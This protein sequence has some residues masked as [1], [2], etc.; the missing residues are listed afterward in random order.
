M[1][2]K[3]HEDEMPSIN[4]TP[5]V[6]I[7]FQ[8][9]IFFMVGTKFTEMEKKIDLSVPSVANS[10]TLP[11]APEKRIVNVYRDGRIELDSKSVSLEQLQSEL[12]TW[13][14][15]SAN[16]SVVVRGDAEGALQNVASVLTACRDAGIS[17][18]GISVRVA[19]KQR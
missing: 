5:M 19:K 14:G 2:L 4:L 9:I 18:M 17:D 1:P 10:S 13:R 7:V 6:D 16:Q 11:D 15:R 12:A 8:L 3:M